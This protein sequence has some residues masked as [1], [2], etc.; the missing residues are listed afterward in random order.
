[1]GQL[2]YWVKVREGR[3]DGEGGGGNK[4]GRSDVRCCGDVRMEKLG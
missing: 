3:E 1:M 4:G 2:V